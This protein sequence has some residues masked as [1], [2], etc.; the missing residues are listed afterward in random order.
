MESRCVSLFLLTPFFL[1]FH[2]RDDLAR[3]AS[4]AVERTLHLQSDEGAAELK[5]VFCAYP[6]RDKEGGEEEKFFR[7]S[8]FSSRPITHPFSQVSSS[9]PPPPS[10]AAAAAAAATAARRGRSA[11]EETFPDKEAPFPPPPSPRKAS[12][13]ITM[14]TMMMRREGTNDG[15]RRRSWGGDVER[16]RSC[17][18]V[19]SS[20]SSQYCTNY[21]LY[22]L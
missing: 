19:M 7:T 4:S 12:P 2:T 1:L 10:A 16:T 20:L 22:V 13:L 5:L 14:K 17:L 18:A 9:F 11:A 15:W 3:L 6:P 8:P 21:N